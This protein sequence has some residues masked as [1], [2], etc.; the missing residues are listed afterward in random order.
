MPHFP[1]SHISK[2]VPSI[3]QVYTTEETRTRREGGDLEDYKA[4]SHIS[5]MVLSTMHVGGHGKT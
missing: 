2:K 5:M 4:P 1:P 3:V